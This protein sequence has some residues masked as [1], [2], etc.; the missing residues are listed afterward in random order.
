MANE[1]T[2]LIVDDTKD[3]RN[4]LAGW[5]SD[6]GHR[7]A[8]A[9]DERKAMEYLGCEV[10]DFIVTDVRLLG[11]DDE[12]DSG[13]QLVKKIREKNINSQIILMT[14]Q[15]V[16]GRHFSA[17]KKYNVLAYIE[18]TTG[19]IEDIAS[20]I[21]NVVLASPRDIVLQFFENVEFEIT[22][23]SEN[24]LVCTTESLWWQELPK[25]YVHFVLGRALDIDEFKVLSATGKD[26]FKND[27]TKKITFVIIDELPESSDLH[28]IF[29]L[30]AQ[31]ALVVIPLSKSLI[32]DSVREGREAQFLMEQV[33]L[34]TG[35]TD[36]YDTRTEVSDFLSFFGRHSLLENIKRQL[37]SG[38][39][40][41]IFGVRKIGKSS[42]LARLIKDTNWPIASIDMQGFVFNL[43]DIF[44]E[45]VDAWQRKFQQIY[46]EFSV[47][48]W[49][50]KIET[51][52]VVERPQVFR[53]AVRSF[54]SIASR[55]IAGF[56]GL[57]LFIDEADL[58]F[59]HD[60][61]FRLSAFFRSLAE[62][63]H[64]KGRFNLLIAGLEP[65]IN[66]HDK[67]SSG[68][69]PFFSFFKEYGVGPLS[70]KDTETMI[71]ALGNPM[72]VSYSNDA[73][74]FLVET[75]GGHPLLTRQLCSYV[76][77]EKPRPIAITLED[78]QR[79]V[80]EYLSFPENYFVSLW[81]LDTGGPRAQED[82]IL[83]VLSRQGSCSHKELLSGNNQVRDLR[84]RELAISH[85]AEQSLIKKH[86]NQW[87]IT[88]P[89]YRYWI[90]RNILNLPVS[91]FDK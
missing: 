82:S 48:N 51:T 49:V 57:F 20:T 15:S 73:L 14:G 72:G 87:E 31:N 54:V 84:A 86:R 91:A 28:Q 38:N 1:Q 70:V 55:E 69:N 23:I 5:L 39:S 59:E 2:I 81:E 17:I 80:E 19:W 43:D 75:G 66:R 65:T 26:V 44:V 27:K 53:K 18:K 12:D 64:L 9:S 13:L 68:R 3:V 37:L 89:L 61:Y 6:Q 42:L 47:P 7:V 71:R 83:R 16:K 24:G 85:L 62:D 41:I 40:I 60:G 52:E 8:V 30:R 32:S 34:F 4:T 22:K 90:Q 78:A 56:P 33:G 21:E 11:Q 76:I 67:I 45:I 74:H 79:R 63:V 29:A 35:K 88:I 50:E 36:H 58:L 10:F 77:R 46:P 25:I